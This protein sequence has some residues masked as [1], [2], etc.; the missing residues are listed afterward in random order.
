[1]K[2]RSDYRRSKQFALVAKA[3]SLC[4]DSLEVSF[5]IA[6]VCSIAPE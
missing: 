6:P 3:V 5:W 1:M 4:F 2:M